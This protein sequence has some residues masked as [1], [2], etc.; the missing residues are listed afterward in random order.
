MSFGRR[1][2]LFFVLIAIVPT[3]ALIGILLFV[4][5]D[6]QRGKADARIAA[7][8]QTALAV[9]GERGNQ[10]R[11]QARRLAR[12]PALAEALRGGPG[13]LQRWARGVADRAAVARVEVVDQADATTAVAGDPDSL[14]FAQV[15]LKRNGRTVGSM[16]VST[17]TGPYYVTQVRRLTQREFVLRRGD[18]LLAA[19]TAPPSRSFGDGETADVT[20]AGSGYRVHQISLSAAEGESLLIMGPKEG[21]GVFGLGRAAVGIM[22]WFL[23][24][25]L[26]LAWALARTLT[27]LHQRVEMQATTDALTGLWNR[28]YMAETLQREVARA[29]RFGHEM[30]LIIIDVDDFKK[31]NDEQGHLQGDIVLAAVADVVREA[32]RS[33][34]VAARYGGDEL[35]LVLVETGLEGATVLGERLAKRMREKEVPLRD[36]GSMGVTISVGVSA[37]PDS[38]DDLESLVDAAD[39]ALLRAKRAGKNQIRTAPVIKVR[40]RGNEPRHRPQPPRRQ[41]RRR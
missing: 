39:R 16:R 1:L 9:Y 11:L 35:A 20:V 28:R 23:V 41:T 13:A 17:T 3:G 38:A 31:I 15:A 4:S 37:I 26:A 18:R 25:A 14:A 32:T 7:G 22:I 12:Q 34:D 27:R 21:S 29:L 40:S 8:L 36:G 10:A 24:T 19:T 5:Q 2:A 33:I 6:A 30:S